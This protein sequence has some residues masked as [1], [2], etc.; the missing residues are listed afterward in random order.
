LLLVCENICKSFDRGI[1]VLKNLSFGIEENSFAC[2]LGSS[3]SG[4][5]TLGMI[6]AGLEPFDSGSI[7]L[8]DRDIAGLPAQKRPINYIFQ[9]YSLFPHMTVEKNIS[10]GL[11]ARNME[12]RIIREKTAE[13]IAKL[14][15][16]G[17]EGRFP[18]QLSGGQKS[19]AALGRALANEPEILILDE[20]LSS[21]DA[22]LRKEIQE[23][24]KLLQ[25]ETGKSF[26]MI[27]HD[28]EEALSLADAIFFLDGGEIIQASPPEEIYNRPKTKKIAEFFGRLNHLPGDSAIR[29]ENVSI[30]ETGEP[31]IVSSCSFRSGGFFEIA[32]ETQ[33]G[34]LIR[35][36]SARKYEN[37]KKIHLEFP[38]NKI[39][40]F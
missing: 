19:R 34:A 28:P 35:A 29:P 15:L 25:K 22:I 36:R 14:R 24:L 20:S 23:E 18:H 4:K 27:T 21:L 40:R 8:R 13:M 10:F 6:V 38:R 2:F 39:M 12:K 7:Y 1:P 17:L 26:I 11:E 37:G 16:S 5:S 31:A 33:E 30:S 9:Q 3:G 32:C